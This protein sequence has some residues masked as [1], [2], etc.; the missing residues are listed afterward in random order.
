MALCPECGK[1]HRNMFTARNCM[2]GVASEYTY[3]L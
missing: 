3:L 2:Q 1:V